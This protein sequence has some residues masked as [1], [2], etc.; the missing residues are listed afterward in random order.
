MGFLQFLSALF[1]WIYTLCWSLSFYPQALL[2]IKKKSTAGTT[3]DFPFVNIL[4]F[5]AYL[6]YTCAF[7]W[8]PVIR[9]QYALRHNGHSPTVALNDVAFA[10]H[11]VVLTALLNTQYFLPWLW[12]FERAP[13]A[14]PSRLMTA[15]FT[16]SLAAIG[17]AMVVVA[18]QPADADP[19]A[20]WAWL[21]VMYVIS[22]VKVFVTVVKY[23]PQL[24]Y[25]WRNR[26][27]QGWSISQILLDF[28][29]GVLSL[30]QLGIDSYL[31]RDWS[32]VT[33]NPVKF[34]LGNVSILYDVGFIAQHY[35]L[36]SDRRKGV[37]GDGERDRLLERGEDDERLD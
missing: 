30:A 4:G 1:G 35:V 31:Q 16:G 37:K 3:V 12:G 19:R 21:D 9:H 8:S 26:S 24:V 33:G 5:V 36:Y 27:T 28:T 29:G 13:G 7:Y 32:G 10:A 34:L 14:K 2:N 25:N 22:Y 20:A 15:A 17:L 23:A 11:A 18:S 6:V